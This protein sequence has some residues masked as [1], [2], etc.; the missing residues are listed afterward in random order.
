MSVLFK[1]GLLLEGEDVD[2]TV[3]TLKYRTGATSALCEAETYQEY[4]V[5]FD[6]EGFVQLRVE[7]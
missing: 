7:G 5:P 1:Y 4:T 3:I 6:S 2:H